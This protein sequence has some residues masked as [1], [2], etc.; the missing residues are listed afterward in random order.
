MKKN[1]KEK[2][3]K[4]LIIGLLSDFIVLLALYI[5]GEKEIL[6]LSIVG[7]VLAGLNIIA[8]FISGNKVS[9]ITKIVTAVIHYFVVVPH[10]LIKTDLKFADWL[11]GSGAT[12]IYYVARVFAFVYICALVVEIVD[13]T[14]LSVFKQS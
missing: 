10:F 11:V 9:A 12:D 1:K 8:C 6:W 7:F 3:I 5:G 2:S 13:N 14:D 4:N